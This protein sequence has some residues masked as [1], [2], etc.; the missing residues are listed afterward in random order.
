MV[1]EIGVDPFA[2]RDRGL[3]GIA[4]LDVNTPLWFPFAGQLLPKNF[5]GL[6]VHA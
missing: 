5:A 4:V 1:A 3:G 6:K 2:V